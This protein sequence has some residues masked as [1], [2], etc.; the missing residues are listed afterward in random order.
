MRLNAVFIVFQQDK[1]NTTINE[2]VAEICCSGQRD[3]V[4]N[5]G[6]SPTDDLS[7]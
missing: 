5:V 7:L 6:H 3:Y 4:A 2:I 1:N